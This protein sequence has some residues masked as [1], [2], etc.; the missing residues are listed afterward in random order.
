VAI[1]KFTEEA[2]KKAS[3]LANPPQELYWRVF[4]K[5]MKKIF[6]DSRSKRPRTEGHYH[7]NEPEH[8]YDEDKLIAIDVSSVAEIKNKAAHMHK[9]QNPQ[10]FMGL[11]A[12]VGKEFW[13]TEY[14]YRA[15]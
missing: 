3:G 14:Y 13:E 2:F 1:H 6:K 12:G 8:F 9:T 5:S 7:E 15:A 11:G 4:P 10:G